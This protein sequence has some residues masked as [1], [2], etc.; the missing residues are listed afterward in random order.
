MKLYHGKFSS[1]LFLIVIMMIVYIFVGTAFQLTGSTVA[2]TIGM[3]GA[4]FY[5]WQ[6]GRARGIIGGAFIAIT[7]GIS[8][9]HAGLVMDPG[10]YFARISGMLFTASTGLVFG[11]MRMLF[12]QLRA[13]ILRRQTMEHELINLNEQLEEEKERSEKLLLNVLPL[14][15]SNRLKENPTH[16]ADTYPE[17]TI[18]FAD[19]VD[20]T[21]T[22]NGIAPNDLVQDLNTI[23]TR[24]D[25]ISIKYGLE[26]IKT[27][28]DSYMAVAGLPDPQSDHAQRAADTALEMLQACRDMTIGGRQINLRVGLNSGEVTA[29]VI[30]TVKFLYDLWGDAVNT[31]SRMESASTPNNIL[32]TEQMY[33][34]LSADYHFAP[35]GIIDIKGKGEM[36]TYY[37]KKKRVPQNN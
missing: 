34:T 8:M 22:S 37:L 20:F 12:D 27:I 16:I 10:H 6:F 9:A 25:E 14:S 17:V 31:A 7:S 32:V 36:K 33:D 5:G 23:F 2:A 15:I 35:R 30:G 29:G 21:K 4:G 11:I 24:F 26:K 19:I 3:A 1:V 28:G 13:E 18:I